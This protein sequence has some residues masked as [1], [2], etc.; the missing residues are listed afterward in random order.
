MTMPIFAWVAYVYRAVAIQ[1]ADTINMVLAASV[2]HMEKADRMKVLEGL[3]R[4]F[5][6][7]VEPVA[8]TKEEWLAQ[9]ASVGIGIDAG[10]E[11][12]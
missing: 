12:N 8:V 11:L 9:M 10:L 4:P 1:N 2:P 7:V 5:I 3:Q 6:E